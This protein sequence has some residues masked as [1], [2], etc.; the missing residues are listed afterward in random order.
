MLLDPH[1]PTHAYPSGHIAATLCIY[2]V[3]A[4]LVIGHAQGWW[5][6]LFLVPAIAMPTLVTLS[7][8]YR[9]EHHPTDVLGSL[10]F[11]ALWIPATYWLIKPSLDRGEPP[12]PTDSPSPE[13]EDAR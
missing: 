4:I 5:R 13:M 8:L 12:V 7:R 11:A 9:G 10:L 2:V 3:V 1:L 6:W